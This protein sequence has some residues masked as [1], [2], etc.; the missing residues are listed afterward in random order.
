MASPSTSSTSSSTITITFLLLNGSDIT[1]SLPSHCSDARASELISHALSIGDSDDLVLVDTAS[2]KR[3]LL[4]SLSCSSS[5]SS[6]S[7]SAAPE[8]SAE[9]ATA[10]GAAGQG[11]GGGDKREP[12]FRDGAVVLALPVPKPPPERVRRR[13]VEGGEGAE[14]RGNNNG[15]GDDTGH[16]SEKE[17]EE[18]EDPF[19]YRP[20]SNRL[21]RFLT[22][23]IRTRGLLPD[24]LLAVL[25][26][27]PTKFYLFL[28]LWPLGAKLASRFSLGPPFILLSIVV[29]IFSN[30][31]KR[32]P[33]EASAYSVFN[34]GFRSLLGE[35]RA[36]AID[37]G[38]RRGNL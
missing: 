16:D 20:P 32:K 4:S 31:G 37:D 6:S 25:V 34:E 1:C 9:A 8:V 5:S 14:A 2:G 15:E 11:G 10:A 33:G 19:R 36:E 38:L 35:L 7:S 12:P 24:P 26:R 28:T 13:R 29:A 21:A 17:E 30:L 27:I 23:S 18:E 22:E 3:I